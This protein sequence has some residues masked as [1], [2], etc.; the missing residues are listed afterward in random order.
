MKKKREWKGVRVMFDS[1]NVL[2]FIH[3]H[4]EAN[5]NKL[6]PGLSRSIYRK[7]AKG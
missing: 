4:G 7:Y 2:T 3:A 1:N 5:D 6:K